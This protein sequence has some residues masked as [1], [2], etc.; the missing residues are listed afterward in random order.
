MKSN[1]KKLRIK[2]KVS[3]PSILLASSLV[4]PILTNSVSAGGVYQVMDNPSKGTRL[5]YSNYGDPHEYKVGERVKM[6]VIFPQDY[7]TLNKVITIKYTFNAD[8]AS[9][10]GRPFYWFSLPKGVTEPISITMKNNQLGNKED[11]SK[12]WNHWQTQTRNVASRYQNKND[13]AGYGNGNPDKWERYNDRTGEVTRSYLGSLNFQFNRMLDEQPGGWY[14]N[15]GRTVDFAR[16]LRDESRSIYIDWEGTN[17]PI[18]EMEVKTEV[19]DPYKFST[20]YFGAGIYTML[21]NM[22]MAN[23]QEVSLPHCMTMAELFGKNIKLPEKDLV[24]NPNDIGQ[25]KRNKIQEAIFSKNTEMQKHLE[26]GKVSIVVN[27][28]GHVSITFSDGSVKNIDEKLLIGQ[29]VKYDKRVTINDPQKTGVKNPKF[30]NDGDVDLV[31]AAIMDANKN[32]SLFMEAIDGKKD[33]ISVDVQGKATIKYKDGSTG[34]IPADKLVYQHLS[35]ADRH[36]PLIPVQTGVKNKLSLDSEEIAKVKNAVWE[37]NKAKLEGDQ[38]VDGDSAISVDNKGTAT[39]EYGDG[40]KNTIPGSSLVYQIP[41]ISEQVEPK[42]PPR[43][44]ADNPDNLSS[45]EIAELKKSLWEANTQIHDKLKGNDM[46]TAIQIAKN[47]T[48]TFIYTDDS[49]D[50]IDGINLVYKNGQ[51]GVPITTLKKTRD[52]DYYLTPLLIN[53]MN[54]IRPADYADAARRFIYDNYTWDGKK[55]TYE[56]EKLSSFMVN[57]GGYVIAPGP[58]WNLKNNT[59]NNF[60]PKTGTRGLEI[61]KNFYSDGIESIARGDDYIEVKGSKNGYGFGIAQLIKL[62]KTQLFITNAGSFNKDDAKKDINKIIDDLKNKGL[63]DEEAKKIKQQ[64]EQKGDSLTKEDID[65]AIEDANKKAQEAKDKEKLKKAQDE[66]KVELN[67]LTNLSPTDKNK[68]EG[69]IS[70][71]DSIEKVRKALE[72][73]R[74]KDAEE[75][76]KKEAE[77]LKQKVTDEANKTL[78]GLDGL[79]DTARNDYKNKIQQANGDES[80]INQIIKDA[81]DKSN[82]NKKKKAEEEAKNEAKKKATEELEKA[83]DLTPEQ[84][85]QFEQAIGDGNKTADEI[86]KEIEKIIK[87]N[88]ENKQKLQDVK[89]KAKDEINNLKYLTEE[90]KEKYRKAID[91]AS[92]ENGIK[93]QVDD[94]KGKNL[95]KAKEEVTKIINGLKEVDQAEKNTAKGKVTTANTVEDVE[96]ALAEIQGKD[97]KKKADKDKVEAN[98]LKDKYK[99]EI[100][101]IQGLDDTKK[102]E[103]QKMIDDAKSKDEMDSILEYAK[104][105]AKRTEAKKKIEGL[106]HLNDAQKNEYISQID[107]VDPSQIDNIVADATKTDTKMETLKKLVDKADSSDVQTKK[108]SS[109]SEKQAAFTSALQEAKKVSPKNGEAASSSQVDN[110]IENLKKAIEGLGADAS[111]S[112]SKAELEKAIASAEEAQKTYKYTKADNALKTEFDSKLAAAKTLKNDTN[113]KQDDIDKAVN[114]L[115]EA[116][117][118]LNG[119]FDLELVDQNPVY[120]KTEP[121]VGTPISDADDQK[122]IKEKIKNIPGGAIVNHKAV[123]DDGGVK[124]AVVEVTVG[125]DKKEIKIPVQKDA[126]KPRI[127]VTPDNITLTRLD[128]T[129]PDV[130]IDAN[131][132]DSGLDDDAIKVEGLP[133]YLD[134]D[135]ATKK[136][137]FKTGNTSVPKT[138]NAGDVKFTVK[139]KDKAGNEETKEVTIKIQNQGDKFK[140]VPKEALVTKNRGEQTGSA[141]GYVKLED[142]GTFPQG[143]SFKWKEGNEEKDDI[144]LDTAGDSI[145]KTVLVKYPDDS[146]KEVKVTFKVQKTNLTAPSANEKANSDLEITP[147][148]NATSLVIKYKDKNNTEQSVTLTKTGDAWTGL[149]KG[150]TEIDDKIILSHEVTAEK[151]EVKLQT[152]ADQYNDSDEVTYTLTKDRAKSPAN[153]VYVKGDINVG[154][155]LTDEDEKL[156]LASLNPADLKGGQ[157]SIERGAKIRQDGDKTVIDVTI[158]Y[159]SDASTSKISVPIVQDKTGPSVSFTGRDLANDKLSISKYEKF[160]GITITATDDGAGVDDTKTQVEGLPDYLEYDKASKKIVIKNTENI[161]RIPEDA[162][163]GDI[164]VKV[165]ASDKLGNVTQKTL[166]IRIEK[167]KDVLT[168]NSPAVIDGS[169]EV[170]KNLSDTDL[171]K[172]KA[173]VQS[174][175]GLTVSVDNN[176]IVDSNGKSVIKVKLTYDDGFTRTIDVEVEQVAKTKYGYNIPDAKDRVKVNDDGNL[177]KEEKEKVLEIIKEKNTDISDKTH[178]IEVE[179]DGSVKITSKDGKDDRDKLPKIPGN[180]LV[181]QSNALTKEVKIP[182]TKIKVK[183]ATKLDDTEK[184]LVKKALQDANNFE[185]NTN[186]DIQGDGTALITFPDGSTKTIDG[187]RLVESDSRVGSI[188]ERTEVKIPVNKVEVNNTSKINEDERE[189]VRKNLADANKILPQG[190]KII[191]NNDGSAKIIFSDDTEKSISADQLVKAKTQVETSASKNPAKKPANKIK[192]DDTTK[193]SPTEVNSVKDSVKKENPEAKEIIVG[194]DGTTRLI[195][196]DKSENIIDGSDLVEAKDPSKK[197]NSMASLNPAVA[198]TEKTKVLDLNNLNDDEIAEVTSKVRKANGKAVD[199]VVS[200]TGNATLKYEDGSENTLKSKDLVEKAELK[201]GS[202]NIENP[203]TKVKV[204]DENRLS[205]EEKKE[206]EKNIRDKNPTL[207]DKVNIQVGNDGSTQIIFDDGSTKSIDKNNLVEQDSNVTPKNNPTLADV[208]NILVPEKRTRVKNITALDDEEKKAV[209]KAVREA[210]EDKKDQLQNANFTVLGDGTLIIKYSDDSI[211]KIAGN[212]LVMVD[213]NG[214]SPLILDVEAFPLDKFKELAKERVKET[215]KA[216]KAEI[217]NS[218]YIDDGIKTRLNKEVETLLEETLRAIDGV[219][220]DDDMPVVVNNGVRQIEDVY[221]DVPPSGDIPGIL[222]RTGARPKVHPVYVQADKGNKDDKTVETKLINSYIV[223]YEDQTFRAEKSVTRAEAVVMLAKLE[224]LSID[225]VSNNIFKDT[226]ENWYIPYLNALYKKGMIE[227]KAGENFRPNEA[228]TRAEFAKMISYI[229]KKNDVKAPFKDIVGHKYEDA[230]NQAFGNGRIKGYPNGKFKPEGKITRAEIVTI[231]NNLYG[232]RT[233]KDSIKDLKIKGFKDLKES[234]WAYYNIV[235]ATNT[236]EVKVD[237]DSKTVQWTRVIG[238]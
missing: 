235:D 2:N 80:K 229:D 227:E 118:K 202:V 120:I 85:K 190:T 137:I 230:I 233:S 167:E 56:E 138:A 133:G 65:K 129:L 92:D 151:S 228:M 76:A 144:T 60:N 50:I 188:A 183:D 234:H 61:Q 160:D 192:V 146:S 103:Y 217:D 15:S 64:I 164:S 142:N 14:E 117:N 175:Q 166:T 181:D 105:E 218:K 88:E 113:A 52:F 19:K 215:A 212:K 170:G 194:A 169:D 70:N 195:Y 96:K 74:K 81:T 154:Q 147:G 107:Y 131:D 123:V 236:H 130:T 97:A 145:E 119:V 100:G 62:D 127:T 196:D 78:E 55:A 143:T 23:L 59:P 224:G 199:V 26:K 95:T 13:A 219:S 178:K 200:K 42:I 148:P 206:V 114:E 126:T 10:R 99:K 193:L 93:T 210:N 84:K 73:A 162:K 168:S 98:S 208:I 226:K 135:K 225:D 46:N 94:A 112:A 116:Q 220:K 20:M 182:S 83:K 191:I 40:T 6:E 79:D 203:D 4:L 69:N 156:V 37:I 141:E 38:L 171:E 125:R 21:G 36:T 68:F 174:Q 28:K 27:E 211:D 30:L 22:R 1:I 63:T 221:Q 29:Y 106:T 176:T 209:E 165:S 17:S 216:E 237:K 71:A 48:A 223:G 124:K 110:L 91:S 231:L 214:S 33:N 122:K 115:Q 82:E 18:V 87:Q 128:D 150:I 109:S 49:K 7:S 108:N 161:K 47:G 198:P 172:V 189:E 57:G 51:G 32:N 136:L 102:K 5:I 140:L 104:S 25:E 67:K 72:D 204:K 45:N 111:V 173:K 207:D 185:P 180:K 134:Y 75:K 8:G 58:G 132:A 155:G 197:S 89:N 101:D 177:T 43:R 121:T 35:L 139:V 163:L 184:G 86:N 11:T 152:R 179:D 24:E 159:S 153:S 213:K 149:T 34:E 3:T 187:K 77:A 53:D 205:D 39:I 186:I 66:A 90:E 44:G 16:K 157:A 54:N 31:K 238:K 232:R 158:L 41:P 9:L 201:A 12:N 222:V